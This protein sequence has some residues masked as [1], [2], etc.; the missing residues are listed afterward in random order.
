V[1][2][3]WGAAT[4][5]FG[6]VSYRI[7]RNGTLVATV[8]GTHSSWKDG[9]RKPLTTYAYTV[10]AV[11]TGLNRG[12][13]S[14]LSVRTKADTTRPSTPRNFRV[15]A[16][17]RG[18]YVKFAWSPSTDNVRVVRYRIYREGRVSPVMWTTGTSIRIYTHKYS[19][20]YVRAVD[21]AGNRSYASR[22]VRGR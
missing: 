8:D 21:A 14:E 9:S 11:D 6:V 16:R 13:P 1:T 20:Y 3:T 2:L 17:Y 7:T 5:D 19:R 15:V 18:G 10:T 12:D 22:H 4:D